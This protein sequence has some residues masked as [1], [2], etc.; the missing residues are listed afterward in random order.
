M[1]LNLG[2]RLFHSHGR[3]ER[4]GGSSSRDL[5]FQF[6]R[7]TANGSVLVVILGHLGSYRI[8]AGPTRE[9]RDAVPVSSH[10][11]IRSSG[12]V[13]AFAILTP[14]GAILQNASPCVRVVRFR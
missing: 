9:G 4:G 5:R 10:A 14:F 7:G 2:F 6:R 1:G 13:R 8:P 11:T 12:T 3:T